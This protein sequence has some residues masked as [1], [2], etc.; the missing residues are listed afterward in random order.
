MRD[1]E[2]PLE[3]RMIQLADMFDALTESD[4]PY[5]PAVPPEKALDIIRAEADAG[6]LD[7]DLVNIMAESQIYRQVFEEDWR[8]L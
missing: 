8:T 4:R 2:I 7:R 6:L 1:A 5:K 3:T